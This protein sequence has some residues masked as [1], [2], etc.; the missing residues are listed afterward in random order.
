MEIIIQN[1]SELP[2]QKEAIYVDTDRHP[3]MFW[4]AYQPISKTTIKGKL[5][6]YV[7][8]EF[9]VVIENDSYWIIPKINK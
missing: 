2:I 5:Y 3:I 4:Q 8:F 7:D 9:R 1:I 6:I